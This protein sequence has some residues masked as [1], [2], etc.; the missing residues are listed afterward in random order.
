MRNTFFSTVFPCFLSNTSVYVIIPV[1]CLKGLT[2]WRISPK[3]LEIADMK[4]SSRLSRVVIVLW[5]LDELQ[6]FPRSRGS[7]RVGLVTSCV[8]ECE[9]RP[10]PPLYQIIFVNI[11]STSLLLHFLA[12]QTR[13]HRQRLC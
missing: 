5:L 7:R 1:K 12:S 10:P 4:C 2:L 13:I 6:R 3:L 8:S 9:L 11:F